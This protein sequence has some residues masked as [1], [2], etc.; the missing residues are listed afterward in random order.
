MSDMLHAVPRAATSFTR[1]VDHFRWSVPF[2]ESAHERLR[3]AIAESCL[4]PQD[5]RPAPLKHLLDIPST[6]SPTRYS[7]SGTH[8]TD[9]DTLALGSWSAPFTVPEE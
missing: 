4:Q 8:C 6:H 2:A 3:H 9:R 1:A 7:R 5:S